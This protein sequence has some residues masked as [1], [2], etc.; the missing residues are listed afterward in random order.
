VANTQNNSQTESTD[1]QNVEKKNSPQPVS[2]SDN[3]I[4]PVVKYLFFGILLITIGLLLGWRASINSD[5]VQY[6]ATQSGSN[7]LVAIENLPYNLVGEFVDRE[8]SA[9]VGYIV[10]YYY[11][12][13]IIDNDDGS[14]IVLSLSLG[15]GLIE[16]FTLSNDASYG[17][18]DYYYDNEQESTAVEEI[19]LNEFDTPETVVYT[20]FRQETKQITYAEVVP[21][22]QQGVLVNIYFKKSDI[23]DEHIRPSM[24]L[25]V[26]YDGEQVGVNK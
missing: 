25:I 22:L 19:R 10:G 6:S 9:G 14:K 8:F 17:I 2:E 1:A 12:S 23:N 11:I 4:P 18:R 26:R 5:T 3:K 20:P 16:T 15:G 13:S 21:M 7:T 24:F